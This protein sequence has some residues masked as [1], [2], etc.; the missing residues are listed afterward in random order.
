M[1]DRKEANLDNYRLGKRQIKFPDLTQ[2]AGN[3]RGQGETVE[4]HLQTLT[5]NSGKLYSEEGI[6]MFGSFPSP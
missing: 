2:L 5:T 3:G 1:S 6:A 4:G